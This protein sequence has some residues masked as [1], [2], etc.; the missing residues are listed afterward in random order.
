[1]LVKVLVSGFSAQSDTNNRRDI[2]MRVDRLTERKIRTARAAARPLKLVDGRGLFLLVQPSGSKYWRLAY[3]HGGKQKTAALGVFPDVTLAK[4]RE[5]RD[6]ARRLLAD[7]V[8]PSEYKKAQR[9]M[10]ERAARDTFEAVATEWLAQHES[11][12]AP[13]HSSKVRRRLERDVYPYIGSRPI[14]SITSPEV[15]QVLRRIEQRSPETAKRARENCGQVFRYAVSTGYATADPTAALKDAL[16]P[17]T[18]EHFAALLNPA[19]IG[20]FLRSVDAFKG[21]AIVATALR[22]APHLFVRPGELRKMRWSEIDWDKR[23]WRYVMG[24]T[25]KEHIVPLSHQAI[26]LLRE[27]EPLTGNG[28][29]VFPGRDPK[30]PMSDAA[31]NAGLRRLGYDTRKE[32]TMHGWRASARSIMHELLGFPAEVVERQL[33]HRVPGALGDTYDRATFLKE[34]KRMMQRWSDFLS[35]LTAGAKVI[36]LRKGKAS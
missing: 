22:I 9:E 12:W 4:A 24:K 33:G 21:T 1:M 20:A 10:A 15:L 17:V 32:L 23:E 16:A 2:D 36:A 8:D 19:D 6:E 25:G 30:K 28:E 26:A 7:N 11:T 29:Y 27:L 31:L 18:R 13:S 14:A 34:R 3:R 5:R 35:E